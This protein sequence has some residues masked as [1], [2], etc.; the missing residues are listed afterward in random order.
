[1][2]PVV[3]SLETSDQQVLDA[4]DRRAQL[5][6]DIHCFCGR[7]NAPA[8]ALEEGAFKKSAQLFE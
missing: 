5:S 1:M 7:T 8:F 2:T 6:S 4:V 3:L